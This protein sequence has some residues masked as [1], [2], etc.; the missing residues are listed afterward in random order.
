MTNHNPEQMSFPGHCVTM[1]ETNRV[2][3]LR[4]ELVTDFYT[5]LAEGWSQ[6]TIDELSADIC[7]CTAMLPEWIR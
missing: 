1:T 4:H 2:F 7:K 3:A 5:A 6:K